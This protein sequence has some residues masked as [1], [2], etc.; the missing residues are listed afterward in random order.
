MEGKGNIMGD[1]MNQKREGKNI[2]ELH[3]I[4][5]EYDLDIQATV[6]AVV[7]CRAKMYEK[8]DKSILKSVIPLMDRLICEAGE[9]KRWM[10]EQRI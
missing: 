2:A 4:A 10:E 3:D 7:E 5:L 1:E 9:Y 8:R 6:E